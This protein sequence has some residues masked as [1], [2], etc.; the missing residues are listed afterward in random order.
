MQSITHYILL[1]ETYLHYITKYSLEKVICYIT[2]SFFYSARLSQGCLLKTSKILHTH[3]LKLY[4]TQNRKEDIYGLT[5]SQPTYLL[6]IYWPSTTSLMLALVKW[7]PIL[8]VKPQGSHS[9]ADSWILPDV[10]NYI[11][12]FQIV[13][14]YTT[15]LVTEKIIISLLSRIIE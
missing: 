9:P 11:T 10:C 1:I 13:V 7:S 8:T 3:M 14:P 12:E 6:D 5:Y 15:L 2:H 4:L